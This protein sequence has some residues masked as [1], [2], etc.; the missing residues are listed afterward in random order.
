MKAKYLKVAAVIS[1]AACPY[2]FATE[3]VS[4]GEVKVTANKI[5]E[6]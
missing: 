6:N 5:E 3:S 2:I 4:L 1:L